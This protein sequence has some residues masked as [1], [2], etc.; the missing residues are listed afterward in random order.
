MKK[1][2]QKLCA[3]DNKGGGRESWEFLMLYQSFIKI[4]K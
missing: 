4:D 1:N 2:V 3:D